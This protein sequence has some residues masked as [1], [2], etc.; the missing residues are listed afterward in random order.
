MAAT[1]RTERLAITSAAHRAAFRSAVSSSSFWSKRGMPITSDVGGGV[2]AK[3][4]STVRLGRMTVAFENDA[5]LSLPETSRPADVFSTSDRL[6]SGHSTHTHPFNGPFSGTTQVSRY[7]KGKTNLDFTEAR[8]SGWQWHQL[9]H[10]QVSTLLQADNHTPAPHRSVFYRPDALPAAQP[11]VSKH[12][13]TQH[14]INKQVDITK[15]KKTHTT[16]YKGPIKK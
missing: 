9:G 13:R 14:S 16:C 5:G 12:W 6:P 3:V 11:T 7:Q 10:K 8:D 15:Q 1:G 4:G 2:R